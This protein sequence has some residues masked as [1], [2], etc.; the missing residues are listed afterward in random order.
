M[1]DNLVQPEEQCPSCDSSDL[2]ILHSVETMIT[3]VGYTKGRVVVDHAGD[4]NVLN[5]YEVCCNNCGNTWP[6]ETGIVNITDLP[7]GEQMSTITRG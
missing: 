2:S 3:I 1:V 5:E 4:D 6:T 7:D